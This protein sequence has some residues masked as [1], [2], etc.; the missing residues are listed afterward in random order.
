MTPFVATPITRIFRL[1]DVLCASGLSRST[2]YLRVADGTFT[3]PVPL[4]SR[5]VG[6]PATEVD[7]INKA[8]IAGKSDDDIR[9]LVK[10]LEQARSC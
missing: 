5:L 2:L 7:A 3:S 6:W 1:T 9:A 10:N 8:R 4:G